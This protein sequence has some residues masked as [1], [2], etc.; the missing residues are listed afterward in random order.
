MPYSDLEEKIISEALNLCDQGLYDESL[1]ILKK[2]FSPYKFSLV[3]LEIAKSQLANKDISGARDAFQ[4]AAKNIEMILNQE[5]CSKRT[6]LFSNKITAGVTELHK[7]LIAQ[8]DQIALK[9]L[10]LFHPKFEKYLSNDVFAES[11][12]VEDEVKTIKKKVKDLETENSQ[13]REEI[14]NQQ[15]D[16]AK[17]VDELGKMNASTKSKNVEIFDGKKILVL[18]D[19]AITKASIME[20]AKCDFDVKSSQLEL[21]SDYKDNKHFDINRLKNSTQYYGIII[22]PNPHKMTGVG[23]NSSIVKTLKNSNN[24]PP[25]TEARTKSGVLKITKESFRKALRELTKISS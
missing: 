19:L 7:K 16:F 8:K 24:Y 4:A 9:E 11:I 23:D 14:E 1:A 25:F 17:I 22:G 18:G 2:M 5:K 20:V 13:L 21:S 10:R 12:L 6:Q 3:Q 15:A